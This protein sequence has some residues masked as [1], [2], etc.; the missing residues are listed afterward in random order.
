MIRLEVTDKCIGCPFLEVS[1][2]YLTAISQE[3]LGDIECTRK[4]LCDRLEAYLRAQPA[5]QIPEGLEA[6]G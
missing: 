6:D 3:T 2:L 4:D 5:I 1:T